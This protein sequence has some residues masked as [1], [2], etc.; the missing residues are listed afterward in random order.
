MAINARSGDTGGGADLGD[1]YRVIALVGNQICC[2]R[3]DSLFPFRVTSSIRGR[4]SPSVLLAMAL[5]PSVLTFIMRGYYLV[6]VARVVTRKSRAAVAAAAH[7][8]RRR[9]GRLSRRHHG[10]RVFQPR[11]DRRWGLNVR[12]LTEWPACDSER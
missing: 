7:D 12:G 2:G 4:S 9:A 1:R 11:P 6:I 5:P 10:S 3:E 8:D